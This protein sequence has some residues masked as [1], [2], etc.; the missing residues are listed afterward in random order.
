MDVATELHRLVGSLSREEGVF[1]RAFPVVNGPVP[2]LVREVAEEAERAW[3]QYAVP[4]ATGPDTVSEIDQAISPTD[5]E[6]AVKLM[7]CLAAEYLVYPGRPRRDRAHAHRTAER[8][9][10][11]LGHRSVWHTNISDLTAGGRAWSPVT[12]HSFDGL[13]AGTGEGFTV[14]LLQVGED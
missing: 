10:D 3:E 4:G 7:T 9:A 5:R 2:K 1:G 8:V 14:V 6:H 13:V 12:R 11:L